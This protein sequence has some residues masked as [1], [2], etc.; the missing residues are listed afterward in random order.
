MI[1]IGPTGKIIQGSVFDVSKDS[2]EFALRRYDPLLYIRWN[3]KK[4]A[5]MGVWEIRRRPEKMTAVYHGSFEG[6]PFYTLE[7]KE[8]D[9][10][11][12]VLDV[13][14]LGYHVL[15]KLKA[16]DTWEVHKFADALEYSEE[17]QQ[18]K[19]QS[20]AKEDLTYHIKQH[21]KEFQTFRDLVASG[22]NPARILGNW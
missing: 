21:K 13:P 11:S 10:V 17:K 7:H 1:E 6:K 20:K 5:G 12:H 4:N 16:M 22:H 2:L 14:I 8:L 19:I 9:V 18:E 15:S 3:T